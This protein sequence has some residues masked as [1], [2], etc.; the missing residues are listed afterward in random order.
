MAPQSRLEADQPNAL[1]EIAATEV[2][3]KTSKNRT[4]APR[5]GDSEAQMSTRKRHNV[6][7]EG[8][9]LNL[10][11]VAAPEVINPHKHAEGDDLED[12]E[13]PVK[14]PAA[15]KQQNTRD[16]N[17]S[18][19]ATQIYIHS[20]LVFWSIMGTLARL[21]IQ[22]L[23]FYPGAP[24]VFSNLWANVGGT[25]VMG[26]LVEDHT[27]F[28]EEWGTPNTALMA[29]SGKVKADDDDEGTLTSEDGRKEA[30]AKHGKVK[31]TIPL[32]IGLTTG[33]C[34]SFTSFSTFM[35][36]ACRALVGPSGSRLLAWGS[37]HEHLAAGSTI[38][39]R[40]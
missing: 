12:V 8:T 14:Q 4:A 11:E 23:T 31:K 7:D 25:L 22:W 35:R 34:G 26:F 6:D 32:Y 20:N 2:D 33:F 40:I 5:Y 28:R 29:L 13:K 10:S 15:D 17:H 24:V 19:W 18:Q 1:P 9:N 30:L 39:A 36:D 21:G 37:L 38:R 3:H 27:L 16:E